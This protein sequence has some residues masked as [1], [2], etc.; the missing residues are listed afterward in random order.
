MRELAQVFALDICA[1][2]VMSNHYHMALNIHA[3]QAKAWS[4][5]E[6]VDRWHILFKGVPLTHR[7]LAGSLQTKAEMDVVENLAA[8]WRDHLM[9]IS[10]FMRVLNE[11]IAR[12]ANF[13]DQCT[14]RFYKGHPWPLPKARFARANSFRTNWS[15]G[16]I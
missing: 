8:Q 1:Y 5:K 15:G 10:W 12:Q 4:T 13:E 11:G 16:S 14:G 9:D 2:A 7:Y 3:A 6:V